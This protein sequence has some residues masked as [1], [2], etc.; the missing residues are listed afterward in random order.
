MRAVGDF[1]EASEGQCPG[2]PASGA[3]RRQCIAATM[4]DHGGP[5]D[6]RDFVAQVRI[7]QQG[8]TGGERFGRGRPALDQQRGELPD[9]LAGLRSAE[10]VQVQEGANRPGGLV[11]QAEREIL[12][13]PARHRVRPAVAL[14]EAGRGAHEGQGTGPRRVAR[15]ESQRDQP[16]QRPAAHARAFRRAIGHGIDHRVEVPEGDVA[17]ESVTGKVDEMKAE[18]PG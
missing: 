11:A 6:R 14:H 18:L 1:H 15:G 4:D 16:A 5:V 3:H 8:E 12:Q 13:R 10:R 7:V 17:R 9:P 2:E